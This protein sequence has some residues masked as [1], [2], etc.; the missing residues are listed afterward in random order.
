MG[1]LDL[2]S[3]FGS[4]LAIYDQTGNL[5]FNGN[6]GFFSSKWRITLP[7]GAE[8]GLVRTRMSFLTKRFEYDAGARGVYEITS[9]AFSREYE[10]RSVSGELKARF[11]RINGWF[12]A[13]AYLLD[14]VSETLDSYEL[15]SVIMGVHA[16]QK[17]QRQ[18]ATD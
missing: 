18:A 5:R 10:V 9:P 6:F 2:K 1:Q 12:E 15:I 17:R 8:I 7:D 11:D 4:S 14:N 3:A 13:G 16:I